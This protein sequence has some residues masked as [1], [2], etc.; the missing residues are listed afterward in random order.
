M[1]SAAPRCVSACLTCRGSRL[2]STRSAR[3]DSQARKRRTASSSS[4]SRVRSGRQEHQRVGVE[5]GGVA[6]AA[7]GWRR[8]RSPP[9]TPAPG[10]R[11]SRRRAPPG[12]RRGRPGRPGRTGAG[13]GRGRTRPP[14]AGPGAGAARA[15]AAPGPGRAG[16]ARRGPRPAWSRWAGWSTSSAGRPGRGRS[17]PRPAGAGRRRR[18]RATRRAS[19]QPSLTRRSS[20]PRWAAAAT[21]RRAEVDRPRHAPAGRVAAQVGVLAVDAQ[22]QRVWARPRPSRSPA[23][24]CPEVAGQLELHP[25]VVDRDVGRHDQRVPVAFSHSCGSRPPSGAARPGCAG[26]C[27]ASTSRCRAGRRAP[28]GSGRRPSCRCS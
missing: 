2:S 4:C 6:R 22:G 24:S 13:G 21:R 23:P 17:P 8:R 16:A 1:P 26:T 9:G 15:P 27:P 28:G 14:G 10:C 19:T 7:R 3:I 18:R 5:A 12:A 25:R 11:G 20:S